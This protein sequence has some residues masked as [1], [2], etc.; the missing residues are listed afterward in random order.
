MRGRD[1][2]RGKEKGEEEGRG[3]VAGGF[4]RRRVEKESLALPGEGGG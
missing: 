2:C 1:E 3:G 4:G